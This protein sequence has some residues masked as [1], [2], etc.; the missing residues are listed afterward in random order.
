M[1][2]HT[3]R[4]TLHT[5]HFTLRASHLILHTSHLIPHTSYLTPH[6]LCFLPDIVYLTFYILCYIYIPKFAFRTLHLIVYTP[7]S[8][9]NQQEFNHQRVD[10]ALRNLTIWYVF[11]PIPLVLLPYPLSLSFPLSLSSLC[12]QNP[13]LGA[14]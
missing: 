3:S 4:L 2:A 13:S 14:P 6:N 11:R 10:Q 9:T 12:Y 5:S 8:T 1:V 7:Q